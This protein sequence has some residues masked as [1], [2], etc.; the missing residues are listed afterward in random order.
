MTKKIPGSSLPLVLI[1][2]I[3]LYLIFWICIVLLS[4]FAPDSAL[5]DISVVIVFLCAL[6]CL[7]SLIVVA[8]FLYLKWDKPRGLPKILAILAATTFGLATLLSL[9]IAWN[10]VALF[11][12]SG[13]TD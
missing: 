2:L 6:V 3:S 7:S 1:S 5:H 11:F 12:S 8:A 4:I 10:M 9:V 13:W